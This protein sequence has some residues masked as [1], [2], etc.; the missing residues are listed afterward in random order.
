M[1]AGNR[2]GLR[3]KIIIGGLQHHTAHMVVGNQIVD[4]SLVVG[5]CPLEGNQEQL[6]DALLR[7]HRSQDRLRLGGL[8]LCFGLN[9]RRRAKDRGED[10]EQCQTME[11]TS[12]LRTS[13]IG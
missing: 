12:Q 6:S 4:L 5:I 9:G 8:E 7:R 10:D 2:I 11:E 3:K 13:P 1:G